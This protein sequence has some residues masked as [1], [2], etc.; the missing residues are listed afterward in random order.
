METPIQAE[1][2]P[3]DETSVQQK[4]RNYKYKVNNK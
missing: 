4:H 2:W 1:Q 3:A